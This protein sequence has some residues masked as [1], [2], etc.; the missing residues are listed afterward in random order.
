MTTPC[1]AAEV[2]AIVRA[3][4]V[5][6]PENGRLMVAYALKINNIHRISTGR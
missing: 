6:L 2:Y 3:H 1:E 5:A 4:L